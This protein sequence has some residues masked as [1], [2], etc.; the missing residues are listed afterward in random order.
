MAMTLT[1]RSSVSGWQL[2][3]SSNTV[4]T[5]RAQRMVRLLLRRATLLRHHRLPRRNR[6]SLLFPVSICRCNVHILGNAKPIVVPERHRVSYIPYLFGINKTLMLLSNVVPCRF[7]VP[8]A[9]H[10]ITM[11][12]FLTFALLFIAIVTIYIYYNDRK[13][14]AQPLEVQAFSPH[15]ATVT[16]I[17]ETAQRVKDTGRHPVLD[18]LPPATGRLYVVIG[19]VR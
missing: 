4:S 17:K 16:S 3:S 15:R 8:V 10:L 12:W 5:T 19:G 18:Q 1:H 7:W 6:L 2:S 11:H 14:D 13:L 9:C